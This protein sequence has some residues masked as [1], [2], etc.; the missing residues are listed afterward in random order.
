MEEIARL[1]EKVREDLQ[2]GRSDEEVFQALEPVLGKDPAFDQRLAESLAL[3]SEPKVAKILGR[4]LE[5]SKEKGVRKTIKRSLY[6]LRSKGI[7]VEEA[8]PKRGTSILRPLVAEPPVGMGGPFDFLGQR[9]LVL[10]IPHRGRG[11]TVMEGVI[12]D[13]LGLVGF[14]G[15]E[16]TRREARE[17]LEEIKRE[18]PLPLVEMEASYVAFLFGEAYLTSLR[19][20]ERVPED[21]LQFKSEIG[22]LSKEYERPLIYS[23]LT[24]DEVSAEDYLLRRGGDLLKTDLFSSW[25]IEEETIRPYADQVRE[26]EESRIILHPTQK[27]AR[28]QRIYQ[29]ALSEL[30][31]GER[32]LLYKRR[33][34]EMAYVL[35]KLGRE[36]EARIS[37]AVAVDL[38]KPLNVI[39]PNPFLHQLV[40]RSIFTFLA[41]ADQSEARERS[42]I[43]KP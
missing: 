42:L 10:V 25:R 28:F 39:Q 22:A 40:V 12:S 4:M 24:P 11:E 18:S 26:A 31:T 37:L 7:S 27:E 23:L 35:L 41:E 21:Y 20:D 3:L 14:S 30:F 29:K 13:T 19:R 9:F 33:L 2:S 36:E 6:R 32:R 38:E 5:I 17:F 8:I 34:E 15:W 43:I 1:F 16:M